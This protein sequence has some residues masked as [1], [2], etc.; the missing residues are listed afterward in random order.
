MGTRGTA[1][2]LRAVEITLVEIAHDVT[3]T[4]STSNEYII[5]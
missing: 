2:M 5:I 3:H 4:G 1:L